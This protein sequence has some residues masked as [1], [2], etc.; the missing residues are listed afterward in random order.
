ML[1][2]LA[3][4][5]AP[6]LVGLD[7][8]QTPDLPD[9]APDEELLARALR[10]FG[11]VD[12]LTFQPS[13]PTT[14]PIRLLMGMGC[15]D[16]I[17]READ[18]HPDT[19]GRTPN[20]DRHP[21]FQPLEIPVEG[22]P[23]LTGHHST[24]APGAPIVIVVHGLFDSHVAGY[25][26]E[27][28][29]A[30]RRFGFH[31]VALDLRD[32]GRLLGSEHV[33]SLGLEEGRDLLS[34][35]RTLTRAEGVSVG[36]LGMSY[37][38]HCVVRAAYEA[39]AAGEADVLRGGVMSICGPLDVYEAI[40]AFDDRSRLPKAEGFIDR[41]IFRELLKVMERHLRLRSRGHQL[42][43]NQ[44]YESFVRQVVLPGHPKQPNLVGAFLG[45][46]RSAQPG[47]T[48]AIQ[49]PTLVVHSIDDP[50]VPVIHA[51]RA[52]QAA[53]EN[54]FVHVREVPFGGHVGLGSADGPGT[55]ELLGTFF[56]RL[57][58]G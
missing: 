13:G 45:K 18:Q 12:Q 22:G 26:I 5:F 48:D 11:E 3:C 2:W 55:L 42:S 19:A 8:L 53:G 36:L 32:H 54:P 30:L 29:E 25:V 31:V 47:I 14:N 20:F 1:D 7:T 35:A 43:A 23:V 33:P 27:Y 34:A 21:A 38:G 37:G 4:R 46:A 6:R 44:T 58:D 56:G 40:V 50:L 9:P 15:R 16:L 52:K 28:S 49:V 51:R 24:G 39:S 17:T 41:M 57:R 10:S